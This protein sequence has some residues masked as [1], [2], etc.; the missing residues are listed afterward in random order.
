MRVCRTFK[1]PLIHSFIY[2]DHFYSTFTTTQR[3]SHAAQP[4]RKSWKRGKAWRSYVNDLFSWMCIYQGED[5][6]EENAEKSESEGI[7]FVTKSVLW[8]FKVK[9][10]G[11]D[12]VFQIMR[13]LLVLIFVFLVYR[14]PLLIIIIKTVIIIRIIIR[15]YRAYCFVLSWYVIFICS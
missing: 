4:Q 3:R 12:I 9:K 1:T 6:E 10:V 8:K 11:F 13:R 7:G 15:N 5:E 14:Y 2:S